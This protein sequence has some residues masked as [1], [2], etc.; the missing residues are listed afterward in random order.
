MWFI[1]ELLIVTFL[2]C[3][4]KTFTVVLEKKFVK[5][6]KKQNKPKQTKK[7]NQQKLIIIS[8]VSLEHGLIHVSQP[9]LL[10]AATWDSSRNPQPPDYLTRFYWMTAWEQDFYREN[11]LLA[12]MARTGNF[13]NYGWEDRGGLFQWQSNR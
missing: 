13:Q 10:N 5:I 8:M 1:I 12:H 4:L 9:L 3:I 11:I 6:K 2:Y 7:R